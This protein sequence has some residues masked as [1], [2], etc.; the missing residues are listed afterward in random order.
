MNAGLKTWHALAHL[1][2]WMRAR[3]L[4]EIERGP[5]KRRRCGAPAQTI[6]YRARGWLIE[7]KVTMCPRHSDMVAQRLNAEEIEIID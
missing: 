5:R 4:F 7:L 1:I 6:V 3:C 2:Y